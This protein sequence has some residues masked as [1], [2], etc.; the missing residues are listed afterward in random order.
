[1]HE[2]PC[3]VGCAKCGNKFE[4][5]LSVE[6]NVRKREANVSFLFNT[7]IKNSW[8]CFYLHGTSRHGIVH[9]HS[10]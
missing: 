4:H 5:R 8:K 3:Y 1:M 10:H 9:R 2:K 7:K 6:I